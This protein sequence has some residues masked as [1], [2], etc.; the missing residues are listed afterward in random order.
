M[1]KLRQAQFS[2]GDFVL[3]MPVDPNQNTEATSVVISENDDDAED[4]RVASEGESV[5]DDSPDV[6]PN[7]LEPVIPGSHKVVDE[8]EV[9]S[10]AVPRKY[11]TL[12]LSLRPY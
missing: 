12:A 8:K 1:F 3:K 5:P 7:G 10:V 6:I 9:K 2:A 11:I 4:V